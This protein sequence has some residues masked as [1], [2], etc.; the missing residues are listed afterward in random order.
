MA[1]EVIEMFGAGL[2][3]DQRLMYMMQLL[4]PIGIIY[5]SPLTMTNVSLHPSSP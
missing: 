5:E 1:R 3:E 2:P 4:E